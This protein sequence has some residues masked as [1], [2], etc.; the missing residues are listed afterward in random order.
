[1]TIA[2]SL[3]SLVESCEGGH[4]LCHHL[5]ERRRLGPSSPKKER[6]VTMVIFLLCPVATCGCDHGRFFREEEV[7]PSSP[8]IA[9]SMPRAVFFLSQ[10]RAVE[11]IM[12]D[13]LERG[14]L[15]FQS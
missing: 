8:K 9:R 15:L 2:T 13:L 11:V 12:A 4:G 14:G 6:V 1:M 5:L 10:S 7:C 3:P